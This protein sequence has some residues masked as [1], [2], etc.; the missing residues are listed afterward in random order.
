MSNGWDDQ[1]PWFEN[2]NFVKF[3]LDKVN[4]IDIISKYKLDFTESSSG[5]FTHKM[6]CPLPIHLD[7]QERTASFYFNEESWHCFGC[8]GGSSPI[9][10]ICYYEGIP[11]YKAVE[12]ISKLYRLV[13][14][15]EDELE[16][17][18]S[19]KVPIEH[20]ITPYIYHTGLVIREHL[21]GITNG[22]RPKWKRW[23]D[24]QFKKLD[25]YFENY[26]D[27]RWEEVKANQEKIIQIIQKSSV[28]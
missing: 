13:N 8:N 18:N 2:E 9:D 11:Y 25:Y 28:K 1:E 24:K 3:V 10:F 6:K 17:I 15:G 5:N 23:A 20:T 26:S 22:N 12:K 27:E 16:E 4:M 7:G 19:T 14:V 21:K